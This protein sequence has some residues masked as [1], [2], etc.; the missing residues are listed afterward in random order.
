MLLLPRL[1]LSWVWQGLSSLMGF[2]PFAGQHESEG[3]LIRS[4][5]KVT[6]VSKGWDWTPPLV[7]S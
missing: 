4:V 5:A 3:Q 2:H 6:V 1:G 7:S